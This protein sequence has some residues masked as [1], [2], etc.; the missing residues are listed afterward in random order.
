MVRFRLRFRS[1]DS[2][3]ARRSPPVRRSSHVRLRARRLRPQR[4][5]T[6]T[7]SATRSAH[8]SLISFPRL[9]P[10]SPPSHCRQTQQI[11][12]LG[13]GVWV[14]GRCVSAVR[15]NSFNKSQ[16]HKTQYSQYYTPVHVHKPCWP[17][18]RNS[19]RAA[20]GRDLSLTPYTLRLDYPTADSAPAARHTAARS[21]THARAHTHTHDMRHAALG[22][23]APFMRSLTW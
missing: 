6:S 16:N 15:F 13:F 3:A 21:P 1:V 12:K 14:G 20:R 9:R 19:H 10:P 7:A 22:S 2:S 18:G 8:T 23:H 17:V 5:R 4:S 11:R